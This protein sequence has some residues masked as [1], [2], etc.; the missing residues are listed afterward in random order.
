MPA[1]TSPSSP[2]AD[3]ERMLA[4]LKAQGC[5]T[6]APRRALLRLLADTREPLSVPEMHA[7]VNAGSM[8]KANKSSE[9]EDKKNEGGDET[10]LVTVYRFANLLV[11]MNLARR[12]EFGEGFYR[13]EK[14]ESQTGPHHHHLVCQ[15]CG[16]IED[17]EGCDLGGL[18]G[19][20]ENETGFVV[21]KHQLEFFGACADCRTV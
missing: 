9:A 8:G 18:I 12:I 14:E 3:Y 16:K 19:R 5:R 10:N 6:T 7:A 21:Q 4:A 11:E 20:L 1:E 13:Y 15:K 17:F 2:D